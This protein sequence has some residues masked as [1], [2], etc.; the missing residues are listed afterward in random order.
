MDFTQLPLRPMQQPEMIGW[1][2]LAPG[3]WLLAL[4]TLVLLTVIG[5][6]AYKWLKAFK[7]DPKR[8]AL[9]ELKSIQLQYQE[10]QNKRL[11]AEQCNALL[12]RLALTLYPRQ[13]VAALNG[14][15]WIDFLLKQSNL[16]PLAV[17]AEAPYKA[18]PDFDAEA[19]LEACKR[20]LSDVRGPAHV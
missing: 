4:L 6:L 8:W 5:W 2:P 13:E 9:Q 3:W 10:H 19:L 18:S 20:W 7:Q 15:T 11:L 17:L 16:E 12:K 1:W 14:N